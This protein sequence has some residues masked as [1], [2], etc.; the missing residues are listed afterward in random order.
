MLANVQRVNM[1]A[2]PCMCAC[3]MALLGFHTTVSHDLWH[4]FSKVLC[5]FHSL[6]GLSSDNV[7][8]Y[9]A[10]CSIAALYHRSVQKSLLVSIGQ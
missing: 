10:P 7:A 9:Q 1:Q 2:T 3:C 6:W 5:K 4:S 8:Q